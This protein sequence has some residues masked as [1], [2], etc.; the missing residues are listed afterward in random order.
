M[1]F[2]SRNRL[3]CLVTVLGFA[4][5][6]MFVFLLSVY[7]RQE[8]SVDDFHGNK[9]R[10]YLMVRDQANSSFISAFPN[11]AA[12]VVKDKCPEVESYT[13]IVTRSIEIETANREKL[14]S[15][16]IFADS[17]F[18][19]IFSFPLVEGNAAQVLAVKQSAVISRS[20]AAKVFPEE[21]PVGKNIRVEGMDVTINGVMKDFPQN[22]MFRKADLILNYRMIEQYWGKGILENWGN[23]SFGIFFLAGPGT[24][25]P[26]KAP[27]LLDGFKNDYWIYKQGFSKDLAFVKLQD[28]YFGGIHTSFSELKK[29]DMSLV[30]TYLGIVFLILIV[31]MLNYINLSTSQAMKRGK[32][33]A[34]RKLLGSSRQAV[35]MQ[36][37]IE[38][39][40]MTFISLLLGIFMAFWAEPFFN[41]VLNTDLSLSQQ[42]TP[43]F[44]LV[45]LCGTV[46]I[47]AVSGLFPAW[48]VSRFEPI[49]VVKGTYSYKVKTVYSKVLITFQYVVAIV[50]LIYSVVIVRQNDYLLKFDLGFDKDNLYIMENRL[51]PARRQG[52]RDK[53]MSVSGIANVTFAAGTPLDGGNNSS[54]EYRGEPMSFQHF[55]VDSAF[56]DVFGIQVK[57]TGVSPTGRIVYLN[58]KGYDILQPDEQ[59]YE[60]V[61]NENERFQI[62]GIVDNIHFRSLHETVGPL[63]IDL[64]PDNDIWAWH[65]IIKMAPGT[66]IFRT[67]GLLKAAY[68][69]YS[70]ESN[71]EGKF[72]DEII[73]GKYEAE[74][75]NMKIILSF[76]ILTVIIMMMG[77][78]S[79]ALYYVRQREKEIAI[80]K[81][82]GSTEFEILLLLNRGFLR[83][84]AIA[85]VIAIPVAYYFSAKFL[86]GFAYKISLDAWV[87]LLAG[88]FAVLLS[89]VFVSIQ[90]WRIVISNPVKML[91]SE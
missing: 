44:I 76:T 20:Y 9:D 77:I 69:D 43:G 84:I 17:A 30:S 12:N 31:A 27:L 50:L 41:D 90:S 8:L 54:F 72:A 80:R 62:S 57:P 60:V 87:F 4:V 3:Y 58:Q 10:I 82:Q 28:V 14:K 67:A 37:V 39:A 89:V 40:F 61:L 66:D 49:E 26:A 86:Q 18:F 15:D 74:E 65:I 78:L 73:Q 6:L 7:V 81:L 19:R 38:S 64:R 21:N 45:V 32:E 88:V 34:I 71:I 85:F 35:F 42:F 1:K 75:K 47:S 11:P 59:T 51:E 29:N 68:A 24:D 56:F 63:R 22:T 91:K 46:I 2:F 48:T 33:S 36:Y 13:R 25:L 79:M 52:L 5:S 55:Q 53:L 23:S 16:V 83:I 70:G